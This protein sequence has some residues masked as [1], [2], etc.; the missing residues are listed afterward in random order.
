MPRALKDGIEQRTAANFGEKMDWRGE[1]KAKTH[2][3][4]LQIHLTIDG[5]DTRW[6]VHK[7]EP[8]LSQSKSMMIDV[9]IE[10][11]FSN[12]LNI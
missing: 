11:E 9:C 12:P 2:Y 10:K 7:N 3:R 6:A 4:V 1:K 5:H 8:H